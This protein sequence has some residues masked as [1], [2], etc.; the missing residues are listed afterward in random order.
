MLKQNYVTFVLF[1]YYLLGSAF[2]F[3]YE[4]E[5]DGEKYEIKSDSD[6]TVE[7][8]AGLAAN[9]FTQEEKPREP[10]QENIGLI[11]PIPSMT[12]E[13]ELVKLQSMVYNLNN[14]LDNF[15][16]NA[17]LK[18]PVPEKTLNEELTDLQSMV[19]NIQEDLEIFTNNKD[20]KVAH[21]HSVIIESI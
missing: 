18:E 17:K 14:D 19:G 6:E 13:E 1:S 10:D 20:K 11:E 7:V 3:K 8:V 15:N 12:A 21:K 2:G 5:V 4:V 16:P 9:D